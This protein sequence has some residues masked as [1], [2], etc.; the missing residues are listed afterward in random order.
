MSLSGD[1]YGRRRVR[2]VMGVCGSF[3]AS[4]LQYS[5][6]VCLVSNMRDKVSRLNSPTR[7]AA[8]GKLSCQPGQ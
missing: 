4:R 8:C 2:S 6:E 7:T 1:V 3:I 5:R